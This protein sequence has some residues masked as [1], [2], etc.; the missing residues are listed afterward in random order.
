MKLPTTPPLRYLYIEVLQQRGIR[1]A[2]ATL[3]E[4]YTY[5]LFYLNILADSIATRFFQQIYIQFHYKSL[6]KRFDFST[7]NGKSCGNFTKAL[8]I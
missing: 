6:L 4:K 7:F 5:K 2:A 3:R 8:S 1:N